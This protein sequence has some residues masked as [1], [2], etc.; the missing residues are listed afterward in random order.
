MVL[1]RYGHYEQIPD[2]ASL[3]DVPGLRGAAKLSSTLRQHM[4]LA[5]LF[6]I[7][8]TVDRDTPVGTVDDWEWTGPTEEFAAICKELG[9][10]NL[11][12]RADALA[13]SRT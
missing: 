5:V 12:R 13:R 3:W 7:I 2:K 1:G 9:A 8:A 4:E 6:R 10:E 11:L